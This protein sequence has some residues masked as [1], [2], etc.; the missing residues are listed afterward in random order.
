[1]GAGNFKSEYAGDLD[2]HEAWA[3]LQTDP[4]AQIVDV[5]TTAEWN[6]VGVPDLGGTGRTLLTVEWQSYP[7]MAVTEDFVEQTAALLAG[8]G[9]DRDSPVLFLCRSGGRSGAAATAMTKAGF[10][11][12]YNI[13]DGF[14]GEPDIHHHRGTRK[15]WKASGLPWRQS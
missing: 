6:F 12:A 9:A 8:V 7:S 11:R 5:R 13:S 1:M 10:A 2:C 4:R 14:E 3:L 15:G